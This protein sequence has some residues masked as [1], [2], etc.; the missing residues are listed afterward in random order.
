MWP[1]Y[2]GKNSM[3][4]LSTP[5]LYEVLDNGDSIKMGTCIDTGD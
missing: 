1:W 3:S 5:H 2:V 4:G